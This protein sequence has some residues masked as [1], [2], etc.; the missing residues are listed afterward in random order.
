MSV[1]KAILVGNLGSDPEIRYTQSGKPVVNFTIAT[2]ENWTDQQG[3]KQEKT[4]WH[5]IV[6]FGRQAENCKQY[7]SKGRKVYIEGK[8]QT[9]QWTDQQGQK[10]YTTKINAREVQFLSDRNSSGASAPSGGGGGGGWNQNQNQNQNAPQAAPAAPAPFP[11]AQGG[12][13]GG[14]FNDDDIPF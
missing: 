2:S 14:G 6:V 1:N 9:E 7:L 13:G 12:G 10:R 8:I 4:E 5:K 11:P 3:Q